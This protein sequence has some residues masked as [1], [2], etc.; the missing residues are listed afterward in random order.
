MASVKL[1]FPDFIIEV[2]PSLAAVAPKT[3]E[4]RRE[5]A[6]CSTILELQHML[7]RR[8]DLAGAVMIERLISNHEENVFKAIDLLQE[9]LKDKFKEIKDSLNKLP[10]PSEIEIMVGE[11]LRQLREEGV[12]DLAKLA[13]ELRK[14]LNDKF[15]LSDLCETL[16][17]AYRGDG[18]V[19]KAIQSIEKLVEDATDIRKAIEE[20][21][22]ESEIA[23]AVSKREKERFDEVK[24]KLNEVEKIIQEIHI[25]TIRK[26]EKVKAIIEAGGQE[27][28][29]EAMIFIHEEYNPH[30]T[31]IDVRRKEGALGRKT[32]DVTL[33]RNGTSNYKITIDW[34]KANP[35]KPQIISLSEAQ[36][37]AENA[38]KNREAEASIICTQL[39]EQLPPE[40]NGI[41]FFN[42][43]MMLTSFEFLRL[44][45]ELAEIFIEYEQK[46][47]ER[48][49]DAENVKRVIR[50]LKKGN[51]DMQKTI[52]SLKKARSFLENS[53]S[54]LT[55]Y[56]QHVIN[57]A[58][59]ELR[60]LIDTN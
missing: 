10:E 46:K 28:E 18:R 56:Q 7:S 20:K 60:I 12:V 22:L 40:A 30:Y 44:A 35:S 25:E 41:Y 15:G 31:I 1:E 13:S 24:E 29:K 2:E 26:R 42:N 38:A 59:R 6:K 34:K 55:D 36:E 48:N 5:F 3:M 14:E 21:P 37:V 57:N 16:K 17:N 45:I 23:E 51:P 50:R 52:R 53:I 54:R 27:F 58:I 32:G 49:I 39:A 19:T 43:N 47:Q 9:G 33:T 8:D 4:C 11:K